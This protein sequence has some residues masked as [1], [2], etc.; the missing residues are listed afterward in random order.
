MRVMRG[1][2]GRAHEWD[3]ERLKQQDT[4]DASEMMGIKFDLRIDMMTGEV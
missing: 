1:R 3:V 2:V 4:G